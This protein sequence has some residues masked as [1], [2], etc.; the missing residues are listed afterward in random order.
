MADIDA[1][2]DQLG[3]VSVRDHHQGLMAR[4][5]KGGFGT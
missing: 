5:A 2:A 1:L 3:L 4:P